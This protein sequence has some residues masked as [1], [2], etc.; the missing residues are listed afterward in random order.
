MNQSLEINLDADK[1]NA[2]NQSVELDQVKLLGTFQREFAVDGEKLKR[3]VYNRNK[4]IKYSGSEG[5][6]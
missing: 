4:S 1:L 6:S 3:I 5:L 2:I